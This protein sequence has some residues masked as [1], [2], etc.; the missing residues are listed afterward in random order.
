MEFRVIAL[1]PGRIAA[2]AGK[3]GVRFRRRKQMES[4]VVPC[5]VNT[6]DGRSLAAPEYPV[7]DGTPGP[8]YRAQ[9]ET[10]RTAIDD[11][12]IVYVPLAAEPEAS[13]MDPEQTVMSPIFDDGHRMIFEFQQALIL[14]VTA[15]GELETRFVAVHPVLGVVG[16][17][18]IHRFNIRFAA[19]GSRC[20][21]YLAGSVDLFPHQERE[22]RMARFH[23]PGGA[24]D[25]NFDRRTTSGAPRQ[26]DAEPDRWSAI[27]GVSGTSTDPAGD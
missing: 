15:R 12:R 9:V 16:T 26:R 13:K 21:E 24:A 14:S 3:P 7:P 4:T 2:V 19:L 17:K 10:V 22:T 27:P 5:R 1:Y 18:T 23:I 25:L 8:K 11:R 6:V 20:M